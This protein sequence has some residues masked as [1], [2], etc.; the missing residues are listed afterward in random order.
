MAEIELSVFSRK[1]KQHIPDETLLEKEVRVIVE[2]RNGT[3]AIIHWQFRTDD[4][5][6]KLLH[7][8]PSISA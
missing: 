6:I 4:A 2:E 5:R 8:Y 1:L 7:L 3:H